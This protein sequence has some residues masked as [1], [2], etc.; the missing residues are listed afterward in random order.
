MDNYR[1]VNTKKFHGSHQKL[2]VALLNQKIDRKLNNLL[3]FVL[4]T[5]GATFD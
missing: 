1:I 3:R 5:N 4:F 2:D